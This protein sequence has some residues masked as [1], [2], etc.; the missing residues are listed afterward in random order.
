MTVSRRF[1][2]MPPRAALVLFLALPA[3]GAYHPALR[4]VGGVGGGVGGEWRPSERRRVAAGRLHVWK[5]RSEPLA[6]VERPPNSFEA[7][8]R[9]ILRSAYET[10]SPV[11]R[12]DFRW[13]FLVPWTNKTLTRVDKFIVCSTFIGS[14]FTIQTLFDPG[15]SVGV[16]LSYIAQFFSY[17][18]GDPIGFRLLAVLTS[19]L[20]IAGDLLEEK[21]NGA[22]LSG[23]GPKDWWDVDV[24]DAFP[25]FYN[26]LFIF[27]NGYYILR[28]ILHWDAFVAGIEWEKEVE[29]LYV[30]CFSLLGFRRAQFAR[31]M[32]E[33]NFEVAG[34]NGTTLCVRGEPLD[35][36]FVGLNGSIEIRIGGRV[37]TTLQPY[38]LIGEAS[39]LEHLQSEGGTVHPPAR[40][41]AVAAPGAAY[42]RWPQQ[43]LYLLQ[44]E[45]DSDF[46]FAIQLMISRSLSA[47]LADAREETR[48][49]RANFYSVKDPPTGRKK[50]PRLTETV[51]VGAAQAASAEAQALSRRAEEQARTISQLRLRLAD[52]QKQS[53]DLSATFVA[54]S[55]F[56]ALLVLGLPAEIGL[57]ME[58]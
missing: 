50:W 31:L 45:E 14:S 11:D 52:A 43:A 24:E 54:A 17:A 18:M 22:I 49:L 9:N 57:E 29:D 6:V 16:H 1:I 3:M 27:I 15:A 26:E 32:R 35:S 53:S 51:S 13:E 2:K 5:R 37:S 44:Q 10:I 7:W 19:V 42:V 4:G 28:W 30:N 25:V 58:M 36:L 8:R 47:K 56:V 41:T 40:A 46:S 48:R 20:E 33:A 34:V 12:G 38:Q 55:A 21:G 23:F 39:L